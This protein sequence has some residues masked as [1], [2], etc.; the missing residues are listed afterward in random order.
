MW[1]MIYILLNL[2]GQTLL[3]YQFLLDV[4]VLEDTMKGDLGGLLWKDFKITRCTQLLHLWV[5]SPWC[6]CYGYLYNTFYITQHNHQTSHWI[7]SAQHGVSVILV[8]VAPNWRQFL[9]WEWVESSQLLTLLI[10]SGNE[11]VLFLIISTAAQKLL[12]LV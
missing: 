1:S 10:V 6:N 2:F 8:T 4:F 12:S 7:L 3:K 9:N 5:V 11:R